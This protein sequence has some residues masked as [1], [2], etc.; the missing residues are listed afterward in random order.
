[1]GRQVIKQPDGKYAIFSSIVDN[2]I[3]VNATKE[4]VF[5]FFIEESI[6]DIKR[7]IGDKIKIL[8]E[9][10]KPY[11]QFTMTFDEALDTIQNQHGKEKKEAML[12]F[13]QEDE[14]KGEANNEQ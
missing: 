14:E 12:K 7:T 11:H 3:A 1:M 4:E 5:D 10:G 8:E 9:G 2:F 6:E 13:I